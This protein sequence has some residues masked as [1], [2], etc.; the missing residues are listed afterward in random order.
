MEN[1]L[2]KYI[3]GQASSE[4]IIKVRDYLLAD[5]E[6]LQHLLELMRKLAMEE[7]QLHLENDPFSPETLALRH[8]SKQVGVW[9]SV[10]DKIPDIEEGV[11][12]LPSMLQVLEELILNV[13]GK[14][15]Q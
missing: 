5:T 1:L 12:N 8:S 4:E 11:L 3:A 7:L 14:S 10:V 13:S 15:Q 6:N 9:C 2:N